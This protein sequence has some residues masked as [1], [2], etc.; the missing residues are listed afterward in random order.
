MVKYHPFFI[1]IISTLG[2]MKIMRFNFIFVWGKKR[3][4]HSV[5]KFIKFLRSHNKIM[6]F[7][8]VKMYFIG[9]NWF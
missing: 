4:N 7:I 1:E 8:C 3:L 9:Y 5:G 2:Q 6:Y